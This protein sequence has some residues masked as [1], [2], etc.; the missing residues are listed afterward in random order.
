MIKN[1]L[2]VLLVILVILNVIPVGNT[3]NKSLSGNKL[4]VF[5]LDY[6]IHAIMILF[7]AVIW[8]YGK[9][10]RVEWFS[11]YE[12]TKYS[13][14][15]LSGAVGLELLQLAIPWRSFNPVDMEYNLIGAIGTSIV[16]YSRAK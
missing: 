10:H 11:N 15:V 3:A 13:L 1:L 2:W 4:L 16:V 5:R 12:A 8:L 9:I 7:F 6:L 14:I